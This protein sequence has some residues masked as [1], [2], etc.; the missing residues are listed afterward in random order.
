MEDHVVS[1]NETDRT[2]VALLWHE[3]IVDLISSKDVKQSFPFYS[4]ILDNMC[5]ADYIDR[6]TFQH[7]IW[8]FNE[9]SSLIKT[10]YNNKIYHEEFP[11][12]ATSITP[13]P[14]LVDVRFTKILTKYSTEYNNAVFIYNLTQELD[15]DKKDLITFFQELRLYMKPEI[16][17][18]INPEINTD[19]KPENPNYEEVFE[20]YEITKLDIRRMYR[21]L[22]KN[23]KKEVLEEDV[24]EEGEYV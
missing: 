9:M 3:N 19:T 6:I 11:K 5:F 16:K 20:N 21:Y 10:F 18:E 14:P 13:P 7:Q 22:D 1:I 4:R 17:T 12:T 24:L 23:I 8:Q 15:M 2:I